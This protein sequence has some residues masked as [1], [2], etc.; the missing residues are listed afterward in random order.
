MACT[1]TQLASS[2]AITGR[3]G[4]GFCAAPDGAALFVIGGF[5]GKEMNDV[6]RY[7]IKTDAWTTVPSI[8]NLASL[9]CISKWPDIWIRDVFCYRIPAPKGAGGSQPKQVSNASIKKVFTPLHLRLILIFQVLEDGNDAVEP[10]SVS[11]CGVLQISA[12]SV[13]TNLGRVNNANTSPFGG[14]ALPSLAVG[15]GRTLPGVCCERACNKPVSRFIRSTT[16][17][18]WRSVVL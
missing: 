11:S 16:N 7:D 4:A 6:F 12:G 1:W 5:S 8:S 3:G 17:T 10:F 18:V 13:P 15:L 2:E 14:A 9:P